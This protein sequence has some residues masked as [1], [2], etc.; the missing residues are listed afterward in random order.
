MNSG[1]R[2]PTPLALAVLG[3]RVTARALVETLPPEHRVQVVAWDAGARP[4][5][6]NRIGIFCGTTAEAE[7]NE[8]RHGF[9]FDARIDAASPQ[10]P[11]QLRSACADFGEWTKLGLWGGAAGGVEMGIGSLL[12]ATRV[13]LRGLAMSSVQAGVMTFASATLTRPGRVLW[14]PLISAGLKAFS[15]GGGRVRPMAA[16]CVQG[17]LFATAVQA[18]GWN[19]GGLVLGGALVGAWA[20]L[21]GFFVQYLLLGND[22]VAAYVRIVNWAS[23]TWGVAAPSLPALLAAWTVLHVLAA[24]A[25]T[26]AA[27]KLRAPPARLRAALERA[28]SPAGAVAQSA[29]ATRWQRVRRELTRWQFWLPLGVV[30]AVFAFTGRPAEELAWLALRFVAI[31][32]LLLTALSFFQPAWL[33]VRL[34]RLGWWGPAAAFA[35]AFARKNPPR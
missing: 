21:Q 11:E 10:A 23:E 9:V 31:A 4:P 35:G 13:P 5:E 14:V 34:R 30:L 2:S 22:L 16:I 29:G 27:W 19:A 18:L 3:H 6:G 7:E 25:T 1:P 20:A 8:R 32:F 24:T 33:A 17:G 26:L 28:A 15:P 12:H